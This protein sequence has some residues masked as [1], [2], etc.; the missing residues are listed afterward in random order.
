[1]KILSLLLLIL[2]F[3]LSIDGL[4]VTK[5]IRRLKSCYQKAVFTQYWIPKEGSKDMLNDGT[6]VSLTGPARYSLRTSS[7]K[8]IAK[9][10]KTTYEKFQ[11]EGTG[12]LKSG[13][14]VNVGSSDTVFEVVDRKKHPFGLGNND[15]NIYPFTSVASNDLPQ[16]TH[17]Y[18]KILDGLKLPSGQ[19]HNGCV[20]IDDTGDSFSGCQLDFYVLEFPFYEKLQDKLPDH[21]N[22]VAKNCKLFNY[23]SSAITK[24]V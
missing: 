17:L 19:V 8:L 12:L 4:V 11:M 6:I 13:V 7:G 22:V 23:T 24:W 20:R 15:N 5:D 3:S 18:I 16:G 9:V 1:M 10:S 14:L 21:V 2:A